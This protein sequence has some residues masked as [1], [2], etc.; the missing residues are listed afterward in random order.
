MPRIGYLRP[1]GPDAMQW[2]AGLSTRG[3]TRL[4]VER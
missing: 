4:L 2:C 3:L 1:P